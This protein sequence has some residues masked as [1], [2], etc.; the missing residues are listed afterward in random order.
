MTPDRKDN[1]RLLVI[2]GAPLAVAAWA[3][4]MAWSRVP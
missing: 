3:A 1:L 4:W 2:V